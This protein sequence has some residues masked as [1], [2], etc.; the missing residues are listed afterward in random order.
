MSTPARRLM[1]SSAS[2]MVGNSMTLCSVRTGM[3]DTAQTYPVPGLLR[4]TSAN[5]MVLLPRRPKSFKSCG[6]EA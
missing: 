2:A 3:I 5:V 6:E 1:A 4:S